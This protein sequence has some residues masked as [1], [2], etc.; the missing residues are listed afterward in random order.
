MPTQSDKWTLLAGIISM[1]H[2]PEA[3]VDINEEDGHKTSAAPMPNL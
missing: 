1:G 2:L 3:L